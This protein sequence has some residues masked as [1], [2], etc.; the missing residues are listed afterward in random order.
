[1]PVRFRAAILGLTLL[2]AATAGADVPETYDHALARGRSLI[3]A[4]APLAAR[5]AFQAALAARP[6][7]PDAL[8]GLC[9]VSLAQ[10]DLDAVAGQATKLGQLATPAARALGHYYWGRNYAA[11]C[12]RDGDADCNLGAARDAYASSLLL[13][14]DPEVRAH[15]QALDAM[16]SRSDLQGSGNEPLSPSDHS[17]APFALAGPVDHP[18]PGCNDEAGDTLCMAD[19]SAD[20]AH[21]PAPFTAYGL[22]RDGTH[23]ND[24]ESLWLQIGEAWW[25]LDPIADFSGGRYTF[26]LA[27][28][29]NAARLVLD[30][31]Y[32]FDT[33]H[34]S[35]SQSGMYVCGV[36]AGRPACVG[37][38][39]THGVSDDDG[40]NGERHGEETWGEAAHDVGLDCVGIMLAGDVL[41]VKSRTKG[42]EAACAALP[43]SGKH[44][45][46]FVVAAGP[47]PGAAPFFF[48]LRPLAPLGWLGSA[49]ADLAHAGAKIAAPVPDLG[50]QLLAAADPLQLRLRIGRT[51][52][53]ANDPKG[54]IA[55]FQAALTLRASDPRALAGM[56]AALLAN[57]DAATA[58]TTADQALSA[59]V[60]GDGARAAA[61]DVIGQA[62]A[63]KGDL[64]GATDA[65]VYALADG[66]DAGI[67]AHLEALAVPF[68]A[69]A[70][71]GPLT[72]AEEFCKRRPA[73]DRCQAMAAGNGTI[74]L[75]ATE[76]PGCTRLCR[77]FDLALPIGGKWWVLVDVP[78]A[79][80][81]STSVTLTTP[82]P[83]RLVIRL[84]TDFSIGVNRRG[85]AKSVI[86]CNVEDKGKPTCVGPVAIYAA[87]DAE[88]DE[89]RSRGHRALGVL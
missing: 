55:A 81:L 66:D 34:T 30:Y 69:R 87:V 1:M 86:V 49:L 82:A 54:A 64:S 10:G 73:D 74:T 11:R 59:A 26:K 32:S 33:H 29:R 52:L 45:L 19:G 89:A 56:A 67:R 36:E 65:Y 3:A 17:L 88:V 39:A 80:T 25:I 46:S 79:S 37:P 75:I 20:G 78:R 72:S 53:A 47:V 23:S 7:D 57:G 15:F 31:S 28:E 22:V 8:A 18:P 83:G 16:V 58:L 60:H 12:S 2:F 6:D 40:Y 27:A 35:L 48:S 85:L 76:K 9:E 62:L 24:H 13:R 51:L 4:G 61:Y 68:T 21:L 70:L 77:E 50:R 5:E 43:A 84:D 14:E 63:A 38:I 41:A 44:K 42:G 71:E